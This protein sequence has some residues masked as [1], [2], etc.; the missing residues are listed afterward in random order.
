MAASAR[1]E[2]CKSKSVTQVLTTISRELLDHNRTNIKKKTDEKRKKKRE[3]IPEDQRH[4][5]RL[6]V[7]TFVNFMNL[8]PCV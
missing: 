3:E 4:N 7:I 5:N 2:I 1:P 8:I 6:E